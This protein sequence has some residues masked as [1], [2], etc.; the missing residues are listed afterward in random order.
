MASQSLNLGNH[1]T[2]DIPRNIKTI[3]DSL[4]TKETMDKF[5][6]LEKRMSERQM[7]QELEAVDTTKRRIILHSSTQ[8]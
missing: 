7:I 4:F 1:F 2:D 6:K 8:L 3:K 5:Y